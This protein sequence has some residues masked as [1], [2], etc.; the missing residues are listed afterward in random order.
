M[1][2]DPKLPPPPDA[3]SKPQAA[4]ATRRP[5]PLPPTQLP[6]CEP[7]DGQQQPDAKA[8]GDAEPEEKQSSG[9]GE[10]DTP[11]VFAGVLASG[12]GRALAVGAACMLA[13]GLTEA[14][15]LFSMI[16]DG[17]RTGGMKGFFQAILA[18]PAAPFASPSRFYYAISWNIGETLLGPP[19]LMLLIGGLVLA[20]RTEIHIFKLSFFYF[21][22]GSLHA[23]AY[24]KM[25]SPVSLMLWAGMLTVSLWLYRRFWKLQEPEED[26]TEN[27]EAEE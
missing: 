19:Y 3:L 1:P 24:L 21:I 5:R 14:C 18:V 23:A 4:A 17:W 13:F 6:P 9:L 20:V 2:E 16:F 7:P 27:E 8:A 22:V 15:H 25:N 26:A 12:V 11:H 10:M